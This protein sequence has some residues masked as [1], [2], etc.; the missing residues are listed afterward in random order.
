MEVRGKG[1]EG[2]YSMK[3]GQQVAGRADYSHTSGK[4][5]HGLDVIHQYSW[6]Q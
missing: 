5:N 1:A 3:K 4:V 2:T 6:Q